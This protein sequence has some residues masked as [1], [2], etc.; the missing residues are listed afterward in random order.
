MSLLCWWL[1]N[2]SILC[3]AIYPVDLEWLWNSVS[4]GN[5]WGLLIPKLIRCTLSAW[6][7][8]VTS[9]S[10]KVGDMK[11][12][13]F[14][15]FFIVMFCF[16]GI[17]VNCNHWERRYNI[18]KHQ[19]NNSHPTLCGFYLEEKRKKGFYQH[20]LGLL[21]PIGKKLSPTLPRD[22]SHTRVYNVRI[23]LTLQPVL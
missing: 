6:W 19:N 21:R 20:G 16:G 7:K 5:R 13:T 15:F 14:F 18:V 17:P 9:V 11:F 4:L 1:I 22:K 2:S 23:S 12:G 10:L 3:K 8:R